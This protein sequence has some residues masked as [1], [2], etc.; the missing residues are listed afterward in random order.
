LNFLVDD[1]EDHIDPAV[2]DRLEKR[3]SACWS[4]LPATIARRFHS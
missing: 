4:P 3:A 1:I 2:I